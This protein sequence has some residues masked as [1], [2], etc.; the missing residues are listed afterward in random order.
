MFLFP[1]PSSLVDFSIDG[2]AGKRKGKQR[3]GKCFHDIHRSSSVFEEGTLAAS[4]QVARREFRQMQ[5]SFENPRDNGYVHKA[6]GFAENAQRHCFPSRALAGERTCI[7]HARMFA[8]A[9]VK[10]QI[11]RGN[12]C[13]RY[14]H[15][16]FAATLLCL[17]TYS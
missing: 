7:V 10:F 1:Q 4:A 15:L 5:F 13:T 9:S 17:L 16:L 6:P 12:Y 8:L 2:K 3:R 11:K 14:K